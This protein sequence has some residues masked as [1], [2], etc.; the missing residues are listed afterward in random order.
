[1]QFQADLINTKVGRPCCIETTAL[2]AAYLAGLAV[3]YWENKEAVINNHHVEA[4]FIPKMEAAKRAELMDGWHQAVKA[5]NVN[6]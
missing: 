4:T 3:G 5:T 2:G 6:R 1:M